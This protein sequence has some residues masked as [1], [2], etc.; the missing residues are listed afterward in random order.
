M[1]FERAFFQPIGCVVD[2]Y[3]RDDS[4]GRFQQADKN[5]CSTKLT[6]PWASLADANA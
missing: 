5:C 3:G 4:T 2:Q 6:S 1:R